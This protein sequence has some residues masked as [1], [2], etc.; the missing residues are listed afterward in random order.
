MAIWHE[1]DLKKQ[2]V[3]AKDNGW[4]AFFEKAGRDYKFSTDILMAIASRETNMRNIIGDRRHGYGIMQVDSRSFPDW[5]NSGLWRDV[6][7]AIQQ[8]A[9]VLDHKRET[10]RNGQGKRLKVKKTTFTGK[11]NLTNAELLRTAIAAYNSGLWAYWGL[12]ERDDPDCRTTGK[13]YS[14]DTL[15]RAKVFQKLLSSV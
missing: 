4:I 1:N 10:V 7:A 6:N 13:D 12:S 15:A 9:L 3:K 5:C 11:P 8:G 14:S 2:F